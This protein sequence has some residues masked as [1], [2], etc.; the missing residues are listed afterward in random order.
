MPFPKYTQSQERQSPL[1]LTNG[2]SPPKQDSGFQ[3]WSWYAS[4]FCPLAQSHKGHWI[5]S[6]P[7]LAGPGHTPLQPRHTQKEAS[8]YTLEVMSPPK[9]D[10]Y[11]LSRAPSICSLHRSRFLHS[12]TFILSPKP[13]PQ[14]LAQES[15]LFPGP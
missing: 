3:K 13:F 7:W 10:S 14:S 12:S 1:L 11:F 4:W 8:E 6:C 2:T 15:Y 5:L 9:Y